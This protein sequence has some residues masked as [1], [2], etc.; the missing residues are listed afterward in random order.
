MAADSPRKIAYEL[1][2]KI[3]VA[4]LDGSG[5]KKITKGVSPDISADGTKVAFNTEEEAGKNFMRHIAVVDVAG[6]NK[7]V[8]KKGL[9]SDNAYGPRLSPDGKQI[10]FAI[11]DGKAWNIGLINADGSEFRYAYK[12]KSESDIMSAPVW[13]PDGK[14]FFAQDMKNIYRLSL[15]G[16]EIAHWEI[17]KCIA[18]GEMSSGGRIDVS[19]D[20]KTLLI[21]ID[22]NE[23]AHRKNWDGP[24]PAVWT[25][26]LE[27]KKGTR[28][29]PKKLFGWDACWLDA[30]TILF[31]TQ[32]AN[33]KSPSLVTMPLR[34]SPSKP[35][36]KGV[37]DPSVSR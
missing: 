15:D 18:N 12:A 5:A 22:M 10:L 37:R 9:P 7:T 3:F 34:G 16:S 4:N 29:T 28:I 13:A 24:F 21:G 17:A 31:L 32:A 8:F 20:G 23:E 14:S 30:S 25:L 35:I 19:P 11:F 33:D 36:V 2:S 27:T 1:E 26:E 6:G